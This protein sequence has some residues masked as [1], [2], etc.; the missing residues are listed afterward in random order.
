MTHVLFENFG[1]ELELV[2]AL[3]PGLEDV[4]QDEIGSLGPESHL[5]R[6]I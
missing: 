6:Q 3:H 2:H 1:A 4:I 5:R